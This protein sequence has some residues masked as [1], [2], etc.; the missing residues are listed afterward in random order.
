M[1]AS[2]SS[3]RPSRAAPTSITMSTSSAPW[4][5]E[6]AASAALTSL[7]CLPLGKPQTTATLRSDP[8][9]SSSGS[10]DGETHTE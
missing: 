2:T 10:I 4:R 5:I 9:G 8:A 3:K 1:S 6:S 7:W